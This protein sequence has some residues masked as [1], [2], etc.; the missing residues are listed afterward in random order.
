MN[1]KS[2]MFEKIWLKGDGIDKEI[3]QIAQEGTLWIAQ[4]AQTCYGRLW[5]AEHDARKEKYFQ[6]FEHPLKDAK[7]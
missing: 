2:L 4:L 5:K 3:D 6:N 7:R 1:K